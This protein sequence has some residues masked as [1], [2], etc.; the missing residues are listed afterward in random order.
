MGFSLTIVES[1]TVYFIQK[2][3]DFE[4]EKKIWH[5]FWWLKYICQMLWKD[6]LLQQRQNYWI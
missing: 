4:F 2:Q 1:T 5:V 3:F 6:I